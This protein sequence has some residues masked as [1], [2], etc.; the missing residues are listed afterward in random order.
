MNVSIEVALHN[1]RRSGRI[2]TE[3]IAPFA[4]LH[5]N[6]GSFFAEKH[7]LAEREEYRAL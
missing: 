1:T 7:F 2:K 6:C 3:F 5:A 4:G